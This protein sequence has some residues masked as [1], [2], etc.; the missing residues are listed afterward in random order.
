M[1][2]FRRWIVVGVVLAGTLSGVMRPVAADVNLYSLVSAFRDPIGRGVA[3]AQVTAVM[4]NCNDLT[5]RGSC[6]ARSTTTCLRGDEVG[7][8]HTD[9]MEEFPHPEPVVRADGL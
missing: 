6:D 3:G 9:S 5:K 4:T 1:A 8:F 2:L 7:L